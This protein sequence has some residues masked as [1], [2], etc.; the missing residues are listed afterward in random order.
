L[1]IQ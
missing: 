1:G